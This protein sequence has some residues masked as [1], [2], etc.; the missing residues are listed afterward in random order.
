M[1]RAQIDPEHTSL[2]VTEPVLNLP[3]VQHNYDQIIFEEFEFQSYL[4]IPGPH[5]TGSIPLTVAAAALAPAD[6]KGNMPECIVVIDSGFSFTNIVPMLNGEVVWSAVRR[7]D[8]GGK[9]LTNYLKE[10]VSFR[11]WYMMDQTHVMS[12]VKDALSFVSLDFGADLDRAKA[13]ARDPTIARAWVLPDFA[14]GSKNYL[15]YPL[16]PDDPRATARPAAGSDS[17]MLWL[18]NERFAVPEIL[19]NPTTIGLKQPGLADATAD[20][21]AALPQDIQGLFW[22]NVL[23]VGGNARM[24]GFGQRLER[25]LRAL[26]P[27]DYPVAVTVSDE[28]VRHL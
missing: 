14:A 11:Q 23:C 5:E 13:N 3:N 28:C 7:V 27:N 17:Q 8:V 18:A 2:L 26:A 15:G 6:A 22:G 19:F 24:P 16:A 21:I 9:L 10:L 20:A 12:A 25:E 1:L 4:R